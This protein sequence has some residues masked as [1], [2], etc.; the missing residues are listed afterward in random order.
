MRS[1]TILSN[2]RK[3]TQLKFDSANQPYMELG[4]LGILH[5]QLFSNI[6]LISDLY[7]PD[8]KLAIE[9]QDPHHYSHV[10]YVVEL[11]IFFLLLT[12]KGIQINLLRLINK[13]MN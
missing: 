4:I 1:H 10:W 8:L 2:A 11:L 5:S 3:S 12:I 6:K 13:E 9:Y 7:I